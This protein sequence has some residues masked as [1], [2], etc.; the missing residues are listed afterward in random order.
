MGILYIHGWYVVCICVH[1]YTLYWRKK[2]CVY[3]YAV[4]E[5]K[6]RVQYWRQYRD[7]FLATIDCCIRKGEVSKKKKE[8]EENIKTEV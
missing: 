5:K 1:I 3:V 2:V 7:I 4:S 6:A 8:E